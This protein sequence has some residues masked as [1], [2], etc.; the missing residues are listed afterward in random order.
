MEAGISPLFLL[1]ASLFRLKNANWKTC[2]ICSED[3]KFNFCFRHDSWKG[4]NCNS[5]ETSWFHKLK[6]FSLNLR[7]VWAAKNNQ[8]RKLNFQWK[9]FFSA[10][11]DDDEA[12]REEKQVDESFRILL[13]HSDAVDYESLVKS[14]ATLFR[15]GRTSSGN[16]VSQSARGWG[17]WKRTPAPARV[18]KFLEIE[19]MV[20]AAAL[21]TTNFQLLSHA[22]RN[23]QIS[24]KKVISFEKSFETI[25]IIEIRVLC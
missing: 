13:C 22:C 25:V 19:K 3:N 16:H 20:F 7:W 9:K 18:K 6:H 17:R 24:R 23:F 21:I 1:F 8:K 14:F 10:T 5:N 4:S 2:I 15:L 12:S 11:T